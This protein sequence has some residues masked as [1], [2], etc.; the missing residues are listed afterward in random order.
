MVVVC[1]HLEL[2]PHHEAHVVKGYLTLFHNISWQ[3]RNAN[4]VNFSGFIFLIRSCSLRCQMLPDYGPPIPVGCI[5]KRQ[6]CLELPSSRSQCRVAVVHIGK[7]VVIFHVVEKK[8]LSSMFLSFNIV[9]SPILHRQPSSMPAR[10]LSVS[11]INILIIF[12]LTRPVSRI[13]INHF[14]A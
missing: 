8:I 5:Q 10:K 1:F 14:F 9:R 4:T 7:Y 6:R 13:N 2:V 3:N 11:R 12:C